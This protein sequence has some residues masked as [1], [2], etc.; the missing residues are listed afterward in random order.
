MNTLHKSALTCLLFMFSNQVTQNKTGDYSN[1]NRTLNATFKAKDSIIYKMYTLRIETTYLKDS[2][3]S[4]ERHLFNPVVIGQ[5]LIF[6]KYG[7]IVNVKANLSRKIYQKLQ[8]GHKIPMLSNVY[9]KAYIVIGK[10]KTAF[11]VDYYGGC[12]SCSETLDF[13]TLSGNPAYKKDSPSAWKHFLKEYGVIN[14][15]KSDN[16]IIIYPPGP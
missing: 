6:L 5:H 4:D 16:E 1:A 12:N 13:Y 9:S 15:N 8:S 2:V 11:A 7:K 14:Y 10:Y 3:S